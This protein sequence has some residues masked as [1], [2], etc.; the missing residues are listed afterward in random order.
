MVIQ[1]HDD[2]RSHEQLDREARCRH[3]A[4]HYKLYSWAE[5]SPD[6][7]MA[8]I[9]AFKELQPMLPI[10]PGAIAYTIGKFFRGPDNPTANT[11]G[12]TNA[13][14]DTSVVR[15]LAA[16][17]VPV[18]KA[19]AYLLSVANEDALLKAWRARRKNGGK[20]AGVDPG[21]AEGTTA[22]GR[23]FNVS[24]D[25]DTQAAMESP[26]VEPRS[27]SAVLMPTK[28]GRSLINVGGVANLPPAA[29]AAS[30]G[31]PEK[32]CAV[33][34]LL[35]RQQ[36][37]EALYRD[38]PNVQDRRVLPVHDEHGQRVLHLMPF[39]QPDGTPTGPQAALPPDI[40]EA[41][42]RSVEEWRAFA[43]ANRDAADMPHPMPPHIVA[44]QERVVAM[45]RDHQARRRKRSA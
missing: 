2:V 7:K 5:H 20:L 1:L 36:D 13:N 18:A 26:V 35:G 39:T 28:N 30:A 24:V 29:A 16:R 43:K 15:E 40:A 14:R 6:Q 32:G 21:S 8:L 25:E 9:L 4:L 3:R 33:V 44:G 10:N 19:Y 17:R 45:F 41:F 27:V 11:L 12:W 42:D 37:L 38:G 34:P 22:G 23:Q 31:A